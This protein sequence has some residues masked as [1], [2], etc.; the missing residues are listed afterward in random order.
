[1]KKWIPLTGVLCL[2]LM[3][4]LSGFGCSES[5]GNTVKCTIDTD[6][7]T[8]QQC[9]G[10]NC[11]LPG[12]PGPKPCT[13]TAECPIGYVCND[14]IC[15]PYQ[16]EPEPD[17]GEDGGD[18]QE[19]DGDAE[20]A[21]GDNQQPADDDTRDFSDLNF[22]V[23]VIRGGSSGPATQCVPNVRPAANQ[24]PVLGDVTVVGGYTLS[25]TVSDGSPQAGATVSLLA[26]PS[27]CVPAPVTT[28]AGGSY[29]FYLPPGDYHLMAV[30][31]AGKVAH[32]RLNGLSS[33]TSRN[34]NMP[35][36]TELTAGP[37]LFNNV[38]QNNWTVM[39]Y[40]RTGALGGE[41]AHN[42][43]T[44]GPPN[45]N[46]EF[47]IPLAE[48]VAYDLLGY[49]PAG[50]NYPLQILYEDVEPTDNILGHPV[51][52]GVTFGGAISVSGAGATGCTVSM[53]DT[54]DPRL[55]A[56]VIS[57]TNGA[58]QALVVAAKTWFV[59]VAPSS[60]AF[61]QGALSYMNPEVFVPTDQTADIEFAQGD[62]VVFRGKIVDGGGAG[63]GDAQVRLL[64]N[65]AVL[66]ENDYS[67]CDPDP[68][69]TN[70]DGTFQVRC[71]LAP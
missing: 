69:A 11:Q 21:D 60:A 70:A 59:S 31:A 18:I 16:D 41:L 55:K 37:L 52:E 43:V 64:I 23:V 7:P 34:I 27:A 44:T 36:T 62:Q 32:D 45:A 30:T 5:G 20:A 10:G 51:R 54:I 58:Y 68:V 35:A 61:G 14:G 33:N 56:E 3:S 9:V 42:G 46:G 19:A 48:G 1:M 15:Q 17:G 50:G 40:Y 25:G 8:G 63:V 28:A 39:G 4:G 67:L 47:T 26:D 22:T 2:A 29:S 13:T 12:D 38:E 49:P 66:A 53:V 65:Q 57:V 6:C 24:G 71:N